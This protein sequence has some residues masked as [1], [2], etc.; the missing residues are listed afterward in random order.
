MRLALVGDYPLNPRKIHNG[1][2]AVFTYLLEGLGQLPDLDIHVITAKRH[3]NEADTLKRDSV[4]YYYLPYPRFPT[5]MS[6]FLLRRRIHKVLNVIQPQ[7]VHA[8]SALRYGAMC[9]TAGYPTVVTPHNVHGAE[10]PFTSGKVNRLRIGLH[11]AVT[12]RTFVKHARHIVSI[13][14]YIRDSYAPL[15]EATFYDIDNPISDPFFRLDPGFEAPNEILCVGLLRTRKRPDLALA[16]LALA[17]ARAPDLHLRFAGAPVEPALYHRLQTFI[18]EHG[19]DHNASFLGHL[20]QDELLDAYQTASI[21]LQASDLETS[22]V[23]VEQAMAAA[24]P[25]VVTDAG[26]TRY[27][28]DNG[29]DGFVVE[30]DNPR[31][32]ADVLIRLAHDDAL[33]RTIGDQARRTALTRFRSAGVAAKMYDMYRQVLNDSGV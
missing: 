15:L 13:S 32:L 1:P 16:A 8:Q 11:F 23:A 26:G 17:V 2:Q 3:L 7:L 19:L 27:L 33:R 29:R 20:T 31:A 14:P 28:V 6:F 5:E 24:K 9:L 18:A 10:M 21:F 30:R 12:R 4:T 22:P 25:V